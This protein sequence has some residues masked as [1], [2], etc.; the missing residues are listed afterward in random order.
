M[1]LIITL[2]AQLPGGKNA[3]KERFI[4][5]RKVRYPNK[6]FTAWRTQAALELI[7]QRT[8]WPMLTK[9]Q[10]PLKGDLKMRVSYH[11]LDHKRRDLTGMT[12]ALY[13]LLE[14]CEIIEDDGQIK[15]MTWEYPWR[16]DGPC[17][18]ITVEVL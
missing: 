10:L 8:K 15:G 9:M 2:T 14:W 16:T 3:I 12:D 13:H 4:L 11:P 5:G 1:T 7:V 6:R 18:S 17:A